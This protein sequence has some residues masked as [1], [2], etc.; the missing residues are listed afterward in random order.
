MKSLIP[1]AKLIYLVR[2]PIERIV[3]HYVHSCE[4]GRE[5]RSIDE[6][7]RQLEGNKYIEPSR[8]Y[9]QLERYL[10]VFPQPQI[11]VIGMEAMRDDREEVLGSVFRF[12]G[13][14]DCFR[15]ARH[16]AAYHVSRKKGRLRRTAERNRFIRGVRP[17]V[18][19]SVVSW[20]ATH[21]RAKASTERPKL[22]AGVG[23]GL[24]SYLRD[25]IE[26]LREKLDQ[27]FVGWSV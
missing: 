18:P 1:D 22:S 17:Y 9:A 3:S 25:D 12:L 19:S 6:A 20:I 13:V 26:R 5:K 10:R 11:L 16:E 21:D 14:D 8:Y 27:E 24:R 23:D 7:L 4:A 15:S 2:D